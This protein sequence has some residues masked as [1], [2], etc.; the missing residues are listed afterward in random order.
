MDLKT[1]G[2][3][4]VFYRTAKEIGGVTASILNSTLFQV[5]NSG[6]D[7]YNIQS[8]SQAAGNSLG[9]GDFCVCFIQ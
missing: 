3:S 9:G 6:I 2:K 4:Y 1:S 8:S 7:T 5:T